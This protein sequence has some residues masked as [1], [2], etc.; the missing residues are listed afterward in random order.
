MS[1]K[2]ISIAEALSLGLLK[3]PEFTRALL[4]I[5]I[6]DAAMSQGYSKQDA[7]EYADLEVEQRK[8]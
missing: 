5:E 1:A 2:R 7:E 4:F 3:D 8:T 6:R